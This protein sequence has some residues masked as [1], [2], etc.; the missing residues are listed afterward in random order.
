MPYTCGLTIISSS[1]RCAVERAE[2]GECIADLR[3]DGCPAD[4]FVGAAALDLAAV[5]V[6]EQ[7]PDSAPATALRAE[8]GHE[9]RVLGEDIPT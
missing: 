8:R 5:R 1:Y 3:G 6:T 7:Q 9:R 4:A 2:K